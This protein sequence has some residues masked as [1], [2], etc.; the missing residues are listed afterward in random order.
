[1]LIADD[2]VTSLRL[3]RYKRFYRAANGGYGGKKKQ[4]GKRGKDLVL[5]VPCGTVV[6]HGEDDTT[7]RKVAD[8]LEPGDRVVIARGGGGGR[9]NVHFASATNQSPNFAERGDPG[10]E[11][12]IRLELRLIADVGIV[13]SPN[14]GKSTLLRAISAARP[15][16]ADFPFTTRE[17]VLGVVLVGSYNFVAIEIPGVIAGAHQGRGLGYGFLRH[18]LRSSL[19]VYLVDGT[20]PEPLADME[21]VRSEVARFD[22]VLAQKAHLVVVNKIDLS[23]VRARLPLL[24]KAFGERGLKP[25][26]VSAATG[27]GVPQLVTEIAKVLNTTGNQESVTPEAG[28]TDLAVLRPQPERHNR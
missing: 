18:A 16:V 22:P 12:S 2:S 20:S 8:L 14:S 4:R 27:D 7:Y 10:E 1:V 9:G 28:D 3:Y 15:V 6:L 13:G 23:E 5:P 11:K 19:L 26:L 25:F 21:V 24:K 17:P